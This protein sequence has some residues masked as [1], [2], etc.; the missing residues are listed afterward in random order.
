MGQQSSANER[1][2]RTYGMASPPGLALRRKIQELVR[3]LPAA[4]VQ[5][6]VRLM[7]LLRDAVRVAQYDVGPVFM[8]SQQIIIKPGQSNVASVNIPQDGQVRSFR[9]ICTNIGADDDTP[10]ADLRNKAGVTSVGVASQNFYS[11]EGNNIVQFAGGP[12]SY[13]P[14]VFNGTAGGANAATIPVNA[15]A[16]SLDGFARRIFIREGT[17]WK[18]GVKNLSTVDRYQV[19]FVVEQYWWDR[20]GPDALEDDC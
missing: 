4:F 17:N 8:Y 12:T 20:E 3:V 11:A 14:G 5:G 1:Q 19:T 18:I 16:G 13:G 2:A 9:W 6:T 15:L 7:G 10:P